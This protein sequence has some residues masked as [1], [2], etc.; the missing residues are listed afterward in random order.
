MLKVLFWS[1]PSPRCICLRRPSGLHL[2]RFEIRVFLLLR[3][4]RSAVPYSVIFGTISLGR[5]TRDFLHPPLGGR[6]P[7]PLYPSAGTTATCGSKT[8]EPIYLTSGV[9]DYVHSPT[10]HA[11]YGGRRKWGTGW[12][13]CAAIEL[14]VPIIKGAIHF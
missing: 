9:C 2:P 12:A 6:A 5:P 7:T 3:Y 8:P 1:F 10:P 4:S 13:L 11:K 14:V